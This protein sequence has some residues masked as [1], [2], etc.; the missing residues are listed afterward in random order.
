MSTPPT[1]ATFNYVLDAGQAEL[2]GK[3]FSEAPAVWK[4]EVQQVSGFNP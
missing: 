4:I 3:Q 1:Q 2:Q